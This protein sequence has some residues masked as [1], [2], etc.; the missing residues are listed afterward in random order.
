MIPVRKLR[1][2]KQACNYFL[3]SGKSTHVLHETI[4][5][6]KE[7]FEYTDINP[8]HVKESLYT[9]LKRKDP[10]VTWPRLQLI[11]IENEDI[12]EE[13]KFFDKK[14]K[15]DQDG[16]S[17]YFTVE[18]ESFYNL[19]MSAVPKNSS[20][21]EIGINMVEENVT[22]NSNCENKG[23]LSESRNDEVG[24]KN[25]EDPNTSEDYLEDI[26]KSKHTYLDLVE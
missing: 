2:Q 11:E 13:L 10:W 20:E 8:K 12:Y 1:T 5:K 23:E 26:Y 3:F 24:G 7:D 18:D 9:S 14:K 21:G 6:N 17:D 4:K 22:R 25:K 19:V 15:P 16:D